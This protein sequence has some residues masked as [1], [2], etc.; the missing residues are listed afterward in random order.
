MN[1]HGEQSFAEVLTAAGAS[2]AAG[3]LVVF[4]FA[5]NYP[6]FAAIAAITLVGGGTSYSTK[7]DPRQ[8]L[9]W[10]NEP[11]MRPLQEDISMLKEHVV[12]APQFDSVRQVILAE[13]DSIARYKRD[14]AERSK[15]NP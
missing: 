7:T 11:L 13:K 1:A 3:S 15:W 12:R 2:I 6:K 5:K 14:S 4:K 9:V 8:I 10:A